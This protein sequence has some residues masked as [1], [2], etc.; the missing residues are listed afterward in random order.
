MNYCASQSKPRSTASPPPPPT[1]QSPFPHPKPHCLPSIPTLN[2][3]SPSH[4]NPH[5][6]HHPIPPLT[7][8]N[9][10]PLK[11]LIYCIYP[12]KLFFLF[13]SLEKEETRKVR[14]E[15]FNGDGVGCGGLRRVEMGKRWRREKLGEKIKWKKEIKTIRRTS[16]QNKI[17]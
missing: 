15:R 13:L 3:T 16:S 7:T 4:H 2:H 9:P 12:K 14:I 1:Y 11:T 8:P 17:K 5:L 6:S 10:K